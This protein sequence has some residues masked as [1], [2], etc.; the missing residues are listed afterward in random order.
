MAKINI[1]GKEYDLDQ[2]P[3]EAKAQLL[4]L[5]LTDAEIQRMNNLIAICQ[6]A[7][8][9]YINA[10]KPHLAAFDAKAVIKS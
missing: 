1:D 7:K 9:G 3:E 8:V 10:L 6:T 2:L 4:S 5:Q